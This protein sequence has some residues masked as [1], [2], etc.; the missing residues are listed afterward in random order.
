MKEFV[1]VGGVIEATPDCPPTNVGSACACFCIEPD[2]NMTILG[3][4]DKLEAK[5]YVTAG[6]SFPQTTLPNMNLKMLAQSIGNVLYEKDI[7]GFV[8]VDL[9]SFPDPTGRST[10]PLF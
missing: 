7:I 1:R 4:Y 3:A 5:R 6:Y 2:G 8:S 9:V 10:H